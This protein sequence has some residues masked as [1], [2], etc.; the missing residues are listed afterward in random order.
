MPSLETLGTT[1]GGP[2]R[3][4]ILLLAAILG[5]VGCAP[6]G[7]GPGQPEP[8]G[9]KAALGVEFDEI[10]A[11]PAFRNANWGVM[12][13][14]IETGEILYRQ[15]AEKLFMPASNNKLVTA[16]VALTRLG[17]DH[18]FLTR[19]AATARPETDGTL[20]G[21]LIIVG[22]GDPAISERFY[23]DDPLAVFRAWADS[24]KARG[25]ERIAGNIVGDD[26]LFDDVHLGPGWAWD[27]LDAYY[28]A[29]IGALLYNEGAV[30]YRIVP[31]DSLGAAA[32]LVSLP[33]TDYLALAADI[34]TVA[35]STEISIR[36]ER[37][38]F[39]NE[40]RLWGS[41]WIG[42]DTVTRYIAPH[43]PTLF[44]VTVL[45]ETLESQGI[46]VGGAAIDADSLDVYPPADTLVTLFTHE[47]PTLTEIVKPFLKRSQNQIGE[48]LLRYLGV[49]ETDTGSV[50]A[51]R[52][53]VEATLTDWG[54]PESSYIYVDGSGL[55]RYNYLSPDAIVRLLRVMA[56]GPEF[57][58][59]YDALPIAGVD[60]T[61][62][63]RM[64]GTLA[65]NN[66]RAKTG[67]ISNSRALSGY[68][69]TRD[70]ELLAFSIIVNNFDESVDAAEYLQDLAIERLANFSRQD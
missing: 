21:D 64:K 18:R 5:A 2:T 13:Q 38:P 41:I 60:G 68:V 28:A 47:S 54:I 37:R 69:T 17:P 16:A 23:D 67:Y 70:G 51:G 6:A 53:A 42:Q 61:L 50:A 59:F 11:D 8:A 34:T 29:E 56:R 1:L 36:A 40:A 63:S 48:M 65:E 10:F 25:V 35:D 32:G 45:R 49:V 12:V 24:L 30:T 19:V 55:S 4:G 52:R 39:T 33:P 46:D 66:A 7:A 15:N 57:D 20:T 14:S 31:G 22:G 9:A 3:P 26:N 44:F 58:V 62:R 27:Y 43:D